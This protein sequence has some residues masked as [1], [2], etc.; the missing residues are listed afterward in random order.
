MSNSNI[1]LNTSGIPLN[2]NRLKRI[3]VRL[4]LS[5]WIKWANTKSTYD[6]QDRQKKKD[7]LKKEEKNSIMNT[8]TKRMLLW[9]HCYQSTDILKYY[10]MFPIT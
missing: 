9:P 1:N 3:A 8:L 2:I 6:F 7:F 5:K 4:T 10:S